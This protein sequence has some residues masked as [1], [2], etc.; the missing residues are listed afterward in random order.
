MSDA[1]GLDSN[2]TENLYTFSV[3]NNGNMNASYELYLDDVELGNG[4]TRISDNYI[5][6]SITRSGSSENPQILSST[7]NR[8]I[9]GAIINKNTTY[10]YTL[11][12]WIDSETTTSVADQVFKAK[13]RLVAIQTEEEAKNYNQNIKAVYTYNENGSGTGLDYTGCLGGEEAG[14]EEIEVSND[15]IYPIGTIVKYEVSPGV[16]RYFNVISDEGNTLIMQQRENTINNIKWISAEDYG[17]TTYASDKGPI[18]ALNALDAATSD[19]ENVN[20]QTYTMG[21][22]VFKTNEFTGCEAYNNCSTNNYTLPERT[23][24]SR[25]ITVQETASLGCTAKTY[26]CPKWMYNFAV[27]GEGYWTMNARTNYQFKYIAW[28]IA[29]SGYTIS[30]DVAHTQPGARAVV[31]INK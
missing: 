21:T 17:S 10:Q 11:R 25:M 24:K 12:L 4:E 2:Y 23:S 13:L 19:W 9:D 18:T 8:K 31:E 5:K 29:S 7:T 20:D 14:C 3:V 30:G 1:Q 22:T 28:L 16:E 6:Y 15:T 26:S 27:N